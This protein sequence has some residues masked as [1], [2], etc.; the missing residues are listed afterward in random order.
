M[1]RGLPSVVSIESVGFNFSE[2]EFGTLVNSTM[3]VWA[4][5]IS[6]SGSWIS[7]YVPSA[8]DVG[9]WDWGRGGSPAARAWVEKG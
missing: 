3:L 4:S 8:N 9:D 1:H 5:E 7:S 2:S 6:L